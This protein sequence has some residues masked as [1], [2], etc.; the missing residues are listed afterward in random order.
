VKNS[1]QMFVFIGGSRNTV[2][3]DCRLIFFVFLNIYFVES[4]GRKINENKLLSGKSTR[5]VFFWFL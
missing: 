2:G 1:L 4:G 3:M 5:F